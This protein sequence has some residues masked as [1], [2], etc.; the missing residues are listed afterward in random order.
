MVLF[1]PDVFSNNSSIYNLRTCPR[2]FDISHPSPTSPVILKLCCHTQKSNLKLFLHSFKSSW[3]MTCSVLSPAM[4]NHRITSTA[5]SRK[6]IFI[7]IFCY[8]VGKI[9]SPKFSLALSATNDSTLSKFK[10]HYSSMLFIIPSISFSL[11]FLYWK[12]TIFNYIVKKAIRNVLPFSCF[13]APVVSNKNTC[14]Q[15]NLCF[16]SWKKSDCWK[17]L[18]LLSYQDMSL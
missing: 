4:C 10:S 12:I 15:P 9:V 3:W 17:Y 13:K 16:L 2:L 6:H 14:L 11:L 5:I 18:Q 7:L 1:C 8:S